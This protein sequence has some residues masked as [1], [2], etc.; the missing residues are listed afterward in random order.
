M[1]A[2]SAALGM[3]VNADALADDIELETEI[4]LALDRS[5]LSRVAEVYVR[6]MLGEVTLRGHSPSA[7][8]AD[9][10]LRVAARV[11]GVRDVINKIEVGP[12]EP[13]PAAA[14]R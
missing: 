9:E 6:S 10:A 2:V 5:G 3:H 13:T 1:G 4:G 7:S 8:A 14:G 11:P 12:P